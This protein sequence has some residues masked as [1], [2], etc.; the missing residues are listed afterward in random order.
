M[1][2]IKAEIKKKIGSFE[3]DVMIESDAK[4]IGILGASGSG[5]SMTLRS[6]AGIEDVDRGHIEVNGRT[7][8]D[9]A[10]KV[11]LRPQKRNVGYMFQNYALFPTM[12]VLQNVMAGL[13]GRS[14]ESKSRAISMISRVGLEGL[15]K[16]LPGELSGGQQQRV[17][18]ARIMVTEPELIL[19]DEPFSALDGYLRDHMQVEMM[20]MLEDYQGQVLMVSHSRDELY[21]FSEELFVVKDGR[22]LR[23]DDTQAVFQDPGRVEVAKLTGCKNFSD[24]RV[25]DS[26]TIDALT[27]GIRLHCE[28]EIPEDTCHIGY[29]AHYFEPVWGDR[30]ENC[31]SFDLAREDILPFERNY[32]VK[33]ECIQDS[34]DAIN[35]SYDDLICWFVQGEEQKMLDERGLPDYL[36]LNE[37]HILFLE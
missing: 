31:I 8:Y 9:S 3:L 23:H 10:E 27:W 30:Q 18:L 34:K 37:K 17:A 19:L 16:R 7:L 25:I 20:E 14:E 4:R 6:I 35:I 2:R 36:K 33:P 5:K 21:R 13:K 29:R 32:Y 22:I 11:N 1:S 15:E 12:T 26:H 24:A 28:R